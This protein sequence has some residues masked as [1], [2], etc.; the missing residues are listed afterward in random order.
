MRTLFTIFI[1]AL[2]AFVACTGG[3]TKQAP[4]KDV[5]EQGITIPSFNGDVLINL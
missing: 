4:K 2:F 3:S 5:A 1:T